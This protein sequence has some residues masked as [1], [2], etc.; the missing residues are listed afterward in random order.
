MNNNTV[1][2]NVERGESNI[3][4]AE[5]FHKM[6]SKWHWFAIAIVIAMV[7]AFII[8]KY[9]VPQYEATATLLIKD[10]DGIMGQMNMLNNVFSNRSQVNFQNEIGTIQS[11]TMVKRTI[12]ALGF[13]T[14]YYCKE[15]MRYVDIYKDA[16]F[17]VVVDL[18]QSQ[19]TG[20]RV[21]VGLSNQN[22]CVVSYNAKDNV[23]VYDY[24]EDRLLEKTT[25]VHKQ[26]VTLK[27]GEWFSKDGMRFKVQL[28]EPEKW[29]ENYSKINYAFTINDLDAVAKAFNATQVEL[30]NKE[31]SIISIKYKHQ[32]KNKAEDFVN[33]L[34]KIY[35]DMTFEEKNYLNIST[36]D[37]VNSQIAAISDSLNIAEKRREIFQQNNNTLNLTNDAAY[38]YERANELEV[39][40]AEA[41]TQR[42]YYNALEEYVNKANLEDGIVVPSTMG[43]QD[44]ILNGLV[45]TLTK[46]VLEKQRLSTTLTPKSPKMKEL[47]LQIETTRQQIQENLRSIK[48]QSDITDRELKRQK[49]LLQVEIDKLPTTQRNMINLERQFKFNDEIYTF[50][51][52]KRAEAEIAKNAALPDHKVIDSA[53]YAVKVYP[54]TAM[55]FLIALVLGLLA[56]GGYIF[57]RY[58]MNNTIE[59]KDDLEKISSNSIL[60]YIPEFSAEY[61]RMIVFSQPK[62]QITESFR[63][64][65]TNIKYILQDDNATEGRIILTTS[66]TPN[67]GKTLTSLNLASVFSLNGAKTLIAGY[68]LRK[69]RLANIFKVNGHAGISTYLIGKSS[70]DEILQHTDFPNLDVLC[71]GPVPPNPSELVDSEKN[72]E[73]LRELKKRY[74]YIILDTPPVSLIAD[75]QCLAKEADVNLF[76]VRSGHTDKGVMRIALSELE[77][78]SNVKVNFVL[79]GI[80]NAMQKYGYGYGKAYG[81]GYGYGYGG[82]YGYGGYGYGYFE[83][84]PSNGK[85][86]KKHKKKV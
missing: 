57:V 79:N 23:P 22:S 38:L 13:H 26:E 42:S 80:Q 72:R 64:L 17:E 46:L 29:N 51:Y 40:R 31:S 34:C 68:D 61:N 25:S 71:S 32:N 56:P 44:P 1:N 52:Q 30:I 86:G 39:Q 77:E 12:K 11:L 48:K 18:Y 59:G 83:D 50:L 37:F 8:T 36:I 9:S 53:K 3:N 74:D 78:R 21:E 45:E 35:I 20:I 55:N 63:S 43:I 75:A 65:R 2:E 15:N 10:N 84:E 14:T 58:W 69:P 24:A 70:L 82:K 16:P 27:Y 5:V 67:D 49:N 73:L 60:G 76:V 47:S 28:K 85:S 41:Y 19:P 7:A 66:S 62:S 6:L 81:Y 54:K 33:M 4:L